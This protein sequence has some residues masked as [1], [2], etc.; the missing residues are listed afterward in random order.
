MKE[1]ISF[2]LTM[3]NTIAIVVLA[4][5]M[6][7]GGNNQSA[8]DLLGVGTR[9][10]HG[11]STNSTAPSAGQV[12]TTTLLAGSL[13]T[14]GDATIGDDLTISGTNLNVNTNYEE[15]SYGSCADATTT[16]ISIVNPFSATSTVDRFIF[17]SS[18]VAT[19]TYSLF[20]GTSTVTALP[21]NTLTFESG[22]GLVRGFN[23]ATSTK[24]YFV[25]G[26]TTMGIDAY[27][28]GGVFT[29]ASQDRIVVGPT[30]YLLALATSSVPTVGDTG[31][32]TV[33]GYHGG[34]MGAFMNASNTFTCTYKIHWI[35]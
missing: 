9:F 22:A 2:I 3:V 34:I 32:Y 20:V 21:R 30:Q 26:R 19:S 29:P 35:R 12:R 1:K 6:L 31:W 7:V 18:G 5:L 8:S 27:T 28:A 17:E 16:I 23:V 13:E 33:T 4:V 15:W 10:V 25:S 24:A 14:T 11:I